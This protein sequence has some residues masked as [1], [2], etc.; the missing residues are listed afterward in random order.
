MH[1]KEAVIVL[2]LVLA[3]CRCCVG[4]PKTES[5]SSSA[6]S[7][8][9]EHDYIKI[10]NTMKQIARSVKREPVNNRTLAKHGNRGYLGLPGLTKAE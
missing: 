2:L 6:G 9:Q 10:A 8:T 7:A 4:G 1:P 3:L 5:P